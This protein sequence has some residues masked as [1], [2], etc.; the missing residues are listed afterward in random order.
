[1]PLKK[2][3]LRLVGADS[4]KMDDNI[5]ALEKAARYGAPEELARLQQAVARAGGLAYALDRVVADQKDELWRRVYFGLGGV[6][7]CLVEDEF[8]GRSLCVSFQYEG[9]NENVIVGLD[10]LEDGNLDTVVNWLSRY[11]ARKD[12]VVVMPLRLETAVA[13]GMHSIRE[14]SFFSREVD[15]YRASFRVAIEN[16][17][18]A[19]GKLTY[20][21]EGMRMRLDELSLDG[22]LVR[23]G[24][25][26]P[27]LQGNYSVLAPEQ[28]ESSEVVSSVS[29]DVGG[30]LESL[31]GYRNPAGIFQ[32][33]A[34]RR[35]GQKRETRI[36]TPDQNWNR[37]NSERALVLGRY[38]VVGVVGRFDIYCNVNCNVVI[39]VG[40]A[41]GC[42]RANFLSG[43]MIE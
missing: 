38:D 33:W 31:S 5:R 25:G 29:S 10:N 26:V 16:V 19:Y 8:L 14:V 36:W 32:C 6:W 23:R 37:H 13:V 41:R 15:A 30:C 3:G 9:K 12:G 2:V 22:V 7:A 4:S 17:W 39:G 20:E 24:V 18:P 42:R 1:V 43:R 27:V 34:S 35:D 40:P 21:C 28:E 11:T